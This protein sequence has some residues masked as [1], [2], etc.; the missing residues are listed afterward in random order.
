MKT[1]AT[2]HQTHLLLFIRKYKLYKFFVSIEV[3]GIKFILN[4][5]HTDCY[6]H[7]AMANCRNRANWCTRELIGL[8]PNPF[9]LNSCIKLISA[10][11]KLLLI[12]VSMR[13]WSIRAEKLMRS[14]TDANAST[15]NMPIT[16]CRQPKKLNE[17]QSYDWMFGGSNSNHSS[18]SRSRLWFEYTET[19]SSSSLSP[20]H[21]TYLSR[22]EC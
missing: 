22:C 2:K 13:T 17:L 10:M 12:W 1:N 5:T 14:V 16:A 7:S 4:W 9:E 3:F 15:R 18:W 19:V 8:I 11:V 20:A 6:T 21:S